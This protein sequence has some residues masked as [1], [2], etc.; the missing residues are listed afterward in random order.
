MHAFLCARMSECLF[1]CM[2]Q[3][4]ILQEILLQ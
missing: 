1:K 2:H 3:Y 4:F